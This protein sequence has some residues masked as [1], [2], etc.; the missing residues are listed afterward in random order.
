PRHR[1]AGRRRYV[2]I[3]HKQQV[4]WQGNGPLPVARRITQRRDGH[5]PGTGRCRG[6]TDI[7]GH[8]TE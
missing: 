4:G 6:L 8:G 1:S 3:R 5:H 7:R 2:R